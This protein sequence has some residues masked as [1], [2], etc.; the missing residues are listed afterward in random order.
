M[1]DR[2]RPRWRARAAFA[3]DLVEKHL[4]AALLLLMVS[5]FLLQI[6][7]RYFFAALP[8]PEELV[9]FLFLW[10]VC[11]GVG[12]AERE[13]KL[14]RF[15]MV[16]DLAG[17]RARRVM[18]LVGHTILVVALVALVWPSIQYIAYMNFRS[19]FVLPIRM[20]LVYAPFLV[21]LAALIARYSWRIR[22]DVRA[23]RT[24]GDAGGGGGRDGGGGPHGTV[25]SAGG[26][27]TVRAPERADGSP[28]RGR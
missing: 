7:M 19:S 5:V 16:A 11:F 21:L 23:L 17:P 18:D 12:Y 2:T 27:G 25:A 14:I 8:W 26:D 20:S 3:L 1:D 10:L 6:V 4:P 9:G 15:G 13:E 22:R 24:G 28:E